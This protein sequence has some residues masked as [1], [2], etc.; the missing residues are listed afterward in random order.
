MLT[1]AERW[2]HGRWRIEPTP[3]LGRQGDLVDVSCASP[4]SCMAV[5]IAPV[6]AERGC[7]Y[8]EL[9]LAERWHRG[10]WS[11]VAAQ[12]HQGS[13]AG[14]GGV[15]CASAN[16]CMAV[17]GLANS[18]FNGPLAQEWTQGR[19]RDRTPAS[20]DAPLWSVSCPTGGGC[21]AVVSSDIPQ[22]ERWNGLLWSAEPMPHRDIELAA[23]SCT[24]A[25]ACVAVGA[26]RDQP[27]S[28]VSGVGTA[29]P[30]GL[31]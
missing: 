28:L 24:T 14:L 27:V 16:T 12:C 7:D 30:P 18:A 17:G 6:G 20:L 22:I 10:R 31:G 13:S 8:A 25:T 11:L 9:A 5:G 26:L 19:W 15:S 29:P 1:L 23:V 3:A 4:F 2:Q 21:L